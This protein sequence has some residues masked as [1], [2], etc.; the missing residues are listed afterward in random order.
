EKSLAEYREYWLRQGRSCEPADRELA[1]RVIREMYA[2]LGKH[3]PYVWW[4]DGPAVGSLVRT[5]LTATLGATLGANLRANLGD[6]LRANLGANLRANLRANL[7]ANLRANLGA[8]LGANLAASLGANLQAN[9]RANLGATLGANLWDTLEA[10]LAWGFW[11]QHEAAWPAFYTWPHLLR[12]MHTGEEL[13]K[14]CW[15]CD[16]SRS[17]GWWHP[18]EQIVFI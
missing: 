11:G 16:L 5:I 9:L 7:G 13:T 1:S 12:S 14:L 6:N 3:M 4:C 17:C 15:W 2:A 10:N 18:F 8:N